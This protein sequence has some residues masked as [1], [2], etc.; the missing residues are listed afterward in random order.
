MISVFCD[1]N[2]ASEFINERIA[3]LKKQF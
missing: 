2:Q 3:L 1:G